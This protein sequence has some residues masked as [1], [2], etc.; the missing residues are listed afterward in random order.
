VEKKDAI[1]RRA[2][3]TV[4]FE[5][6]TTLLKLAAPIL[7]FTT[8][9]M[10]SHLKPFVKEESVL[11]ST[12][13]EV[14]GAYVNEQLEKEWDR[15]WEIREAVNKKIEEKRVEK[16]IGHPL[17]A[18]IRLEVPVGEY[19]LMSKLGDELKDLLIVSQ[20]ELASGDEIGITISSADGEKC[21]RC[22]QYSTDIQTVGEF[23]NLCSRCRAT[24]TS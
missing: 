6:L 18:K 13:P 17:D 11:L 19:E 5:T 23:P 7:S 24:L 16:I 2:S 22:W 10:W 4:V 9:E 8:E 15:I 3:Q 14:N 20:V 21:Q 12:L 1:K